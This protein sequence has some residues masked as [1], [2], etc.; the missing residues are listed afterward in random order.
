MTTTKDAFP[1]ELLRRTTKERLGYFSSKVVAHPR[2]IEAYQSLLDVI[3]EP[4]GAALVI[5]CGPTGVGK[6]T[7]QRRVEQRLIEAAQ[8]EMLRDTR[9]VPVAS[10]EVAPP[11][12]QAFSWKDLY[13]RMLIALHE[14]AALV[15]PKPLAK[16]GSKLAA[17]GDAPAIELPPFARAQSFLDLRW[18]VERSIHERRPAAMLIDEAQHLNRVMG[19]RTLQQQMDTLKSLA[20]TTGV[21]HV[22]IGTYELLNMINLSA[23]LARRSVEIH[24]PRYRSEEEQDME[25]FANIIYTFEQ[26][27]PLKKPSDLLRQ[28]DFLYEG[29]AGCVGTLKDWLT[30]A[31]RCAMDGEAH[32]LT[33]QHLEKT[34]DRRKQFQIVREILEGEETLRA[35]S[36][37]QQLRALLGMEHA[38]RLASKGGREQSTRSNKNP[39]P[40]R[41]PKRSRSRPGQRLPRRDPVGK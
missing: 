16:D 27:L 17:P 10:V 21:L 37:S 23:Q 3:A 18:A 36:T 4:C 5:V 35:G 38:D 11:D 40:I 31:L 33:R 6:T 25:M 15:I 32:A 14:P 9:H 28:R 41:D 39:A 13:R 2:L 30:R 26:H 29:S 24:F 22:L 7:M 12:G 34:L 1:R 8:T 19:A 20:N